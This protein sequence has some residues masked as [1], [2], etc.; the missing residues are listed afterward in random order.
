MHNQ[1]YEIERLKREFEK[2]KHI[3]LVR[4]YE[5]LEVLEKAVNEGVKIPSLQ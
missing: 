1:K 2:H 3:D 4:K 5:S